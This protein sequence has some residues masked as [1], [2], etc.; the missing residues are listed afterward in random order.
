MPAILQSKTRVSPGVNAG[1]NIPGSL[2]HGADSG[3][4]VAI[5]T[6]GKPARRLTNG[7]Q[8]QATQAMQCDSTSGQ[9][10]NYLEPE[11]QSNTPKA[12][13]TNIA[14]TISG[15]VA[16]ATVTATNSF[17]AGQTV[18][19]DGL[20]LLATFLNGFCGVV[21][22]TGLS[23]SSFQCTLTQVFNAIA[24]S[25]GA[26]TGTATL[27]FQAASACLSCSSIEQ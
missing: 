10:G 12:K 13:I 7:Q 16:T 21:L 3:N 9:P 2:I 1:V 11:T 5:A 25:S 19:F 8:R 24:V 18:K 14:I 15:N 20:T 23:G 27:N 26:E 17:L 4:I 6:A 22:A